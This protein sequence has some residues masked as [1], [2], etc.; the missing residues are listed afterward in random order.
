MMNTTRRILTLAG[1]AAG[2]CLTA[3]AAQAADEIKLATDSPIQAESGQV[4]AET[5]RPLAT[6]EGEAT[7]VAPKLFNPLTAFKDKRDYFVAP[8]G[9]FEN[10]QLPGWQLEGGAAVSDGGSTQ[11]VLGA[12][13][14][15]SLMLPPGS[16]A[17]SP[18]MC[19]DLNYP[20]FRFFAAQLEQDTDAELVVD[21][22]Y[23][24]LAKD[25]VRQ[26]KK[27]KLKAKDGWELSNDIKLEPQRL[28]KQAGWRKVAVRFRV[29][30]GKKAATYKID[31]LLI[32]PR[33]SH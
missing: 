10:P 1:C 33:L 15:L 24:A 2:L 14:A 26:A 29:K 5:V 20:S 31:D 32:D 25:N 23:P 18:E 8:E 12:D 27:F 19:V 22:I 9:D 3:P 6:A 17:T 28:G 4:L 30:P 21:V 13:H 16:S 7:C 11:A